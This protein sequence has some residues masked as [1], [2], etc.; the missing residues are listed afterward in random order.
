MRS[1]RDGRLY[2][3]TTIC[4][5]ALPLNTRTLY[6][7]NVYDYAHAY[8]IG[9]LIILPFWSL[10]LY[11]RKD[12]ARELLSMSVIGG[13]LAVLFAP[14]FLH[15]YWHPTYVL[16]LWSFGGIEDFIYGFFIVGIASVVYEELF[17]KKFVKRKGRKKSFSRFALPALVLYA[18]AFYLPVY[19][20]LPSIY[21]ALF[22]FLVLTSVIVSIRHDLLTDTLVSGLIVGLLTLV[23]FLLFVKIYPGVVNRFWDL[24]NVNSTLIIGIPTGELLWAFGLGAAAGPVYEFFAGQR[25]RK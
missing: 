22:S 10:P 5:L 9:S 8:L 14:P 16:P 24:N 13:L 7:Q 4:W 12:L 11:H 20:G 23:G 1:Y 2:P 21:A 3:G 15:D 17:G 6:N 25:F 18:L 19:L